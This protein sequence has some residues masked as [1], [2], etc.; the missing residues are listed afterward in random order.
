MRTYAELGIVKIFESN[1]E[2]HAYEI[3]H[4][5]FMQRLRRVRHVNFAFTIPEI[6]LS[7]KVE[8]GSITAE[9]LRTF[10]VI[11]VNAAA[12]SRWKLSNNSDFLTGL[13]DDFNDILSNENYVHRT[14]IQLVDER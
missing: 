7:N 14:P 13:G 6:C 12:W 3:L 2:P 1:N 4:H 10:S 9:L 8:N 5:E 11:Y